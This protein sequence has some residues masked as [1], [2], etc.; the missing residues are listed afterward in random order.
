[1]QNTPLKPDVAY[2]CRLVALDV[3]LAGALAHY[4]GVAPGLHTQHGPGDPLIERR[5][6]P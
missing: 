1:M 2:L 5:H 3:D 6:D 4:V